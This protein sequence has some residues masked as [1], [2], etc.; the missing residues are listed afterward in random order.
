MTNNLDA[1]FAALSDATRRRIVQHL[2]QGP[3]TVS[4]LHDPGTMALPTFLRHLKVLEGA[5]LVQSQK[6]GRVRHVQL[7]TAALALLED[8]LAQQIFTWN[9]RLDALQ[10][11]AED[12][13][14]NT[15]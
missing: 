11:L 8:W 12:I 6:K 5:G 1:A 15:S 10:T 13:E 3:A 9:G 7:E 4:D 14:R 2:T